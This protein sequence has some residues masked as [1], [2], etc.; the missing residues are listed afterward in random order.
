MHPDTVTAL[1]PVLNCSSRRKR[2]SSN[3]ITLAALLL[4][5]T[6][7]L[8]AEPSFAAVTADEL[9]SDSS[10]AAATA[11]AA[12]GAAGADAPAAVEDVP[13][14]TII[15]TAT[16]REAN[17]QDVPIAISVLSGATIA[18]S[19][20]QSISQLMQL[21][22]S[23]AYYGTNPRNAAINIR[24]LGAPLGLTNDGL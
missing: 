21:Q 18:E 14:D 23:I 6:A 1:L 2:S 22:P 5:S 3:R 8:F 9:T 17:A 16:R 20:T 24:G 19:G 10:E 13:P 11:D 15:I 7:I 4:A 12:A